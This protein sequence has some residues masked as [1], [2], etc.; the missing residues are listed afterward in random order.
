[1]PDSIIPGPTLFEISWEV[2]HR[3]GGIHTVVSTKARTLAARYQGEHRDDYVV[4][5]PWL[6]EQHDPDAVLDPEPA[7]A[8]FEESCRK[9]GLPVRVG[10]WRVPGRPLTILVEFSSLYD[11]KDEILADLWTEHQVDSLFGGWSYVEP[12]L[13]GHAAGMVIEH[14]WREVVN[15]RRR[16][17]VVQAHEWMTG[18]ALMYLSRRVP[19]IGTVFTTHATVIGRAA[20]ERGLLGEN[21]LGGKTPAEAAADLGVRARH[22]IEAASARLADVFTTVSRIAA[23]EA[24]VFHERIPDPVLPNGLDPDVLAARIEGA[25]QETAAGRLRDVASRFLGED[26]SD[27]AV[28]CMSGRYEFRNKGID[29]TLEAAAALNREPGRTIVLFLLVPAGNSGLRRRVSERLAAAEPEGGGPIGISLHHLHDSDGDPI[30]GRCTEL[31]LDNAPGSRVRIVFWSDYLQPGDGILGLRYEAVLQGADATCFPS[32]YEAWGYTPQESLALG[33]PTI[34]TDLAGFGRWAQEEGLAGGDCTVVLARRD[35][36]DADVALE[37]AATLERLTDAG[38]DR[39]TLNDC[40]R[41]VTAATNWSKLISAYDDAHARAAAAAQ[42]RARSLPG[43][44]PSHRVPV[45]SAGQ[46]GRPH[47]FALDVETRIPPAIAGLEE[48]ASNWWWTSDAAATALFEEVCPATWERVRRAPIR[49]LRETQPARLEELASDTEFVARVDETVSRL[50]AY[51]S[52][53]LDERNVSAHRPVAYVCAEFGL[54]ESFPIYS[55]G[56][57]V[58]AGDHLRA[59]SDLGVPLVA[60]GLLYRAG[61]MRQRLRGGI[62]QETE[63]ERVDPADLPLTAAVD[64]D[65]RP[66][67]VT[68]QLPGSEVVLRAW[69]TDVGRVPLYLLDADVPSNRQDDRTLTRSLY[70]GDQ[71]MRI[72]QEIVLGLGS[73]RL[74]RALGIEPSVYHVNEGHGAFTALERVHWLL[75]NTGL[76]FETAHETVRA[77]TVFTTHTPVPAG[78]DEFPEDLVRRYFGHADRW[79]GVP[80]ERFMALGEAVDKPGQFNMTGLAVRFAARVNGVSERHAEVSRPLLQRFAPQL[81]ASEVPVHS[82]TNGVHLGLWTRPA[83][84]DALGASRF[85]TLADAFRGATDSSDAALWQMRETLRSDLRTHLIAHLHKSFAEQGDSPALLGRIEEQLKPDALYIGFARRFATYKRAGLVFSEPDRLLDLLDDPDRPVRLVIAGKAHPRDT[86]AQELLARIGTLARDPRFVGRVIV[87]ENYDMGVAR[88]LVAGVDL[89][90]NTPRRPLEA[91]G[92]S[93]MKAAA[94]GVLNLSVGDG[95]WLEGADGANGWTI[96]GDHGRDATPANDALHDA[97]DATS[98]LGLLR[99]EVIPAFFERDQHGRPP[100]WL[101]LVRRCLV[102]LPPAFDAAR[103]VAEYR[104]WAYEP[105]ASAHADLARDRYN[106]ARD[107]FHDLERVRRTLPAAR[108]TS[109][110]I[111][112]A[113]SVTVGD[114]LEVEVEIELGEL[115]DGDVVVEALVG[116]RA[117]DGGLAEVEAVR[118]TPDGVSA[119]GHARY[120]GAL[121]PREAGAL[122][123]AVRIRPDRAGGPAFDDPVVWA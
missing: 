27:A 82:V 44:P 106:G 49:L 63:P 107:A 40:C 76:S 48:I 120:V 13:F 70:D 57:G 20:A 85:D 87:L 74:L 66:V 22:S 45:R 59:A 41:T 2:A 28:V 94:N 31:G 55:G 93:G 34:T 18:A 102:S 90:L 6:L 122:G 36:D 68:L 109:A 37:L 123:Y 50:R 33:V 104:E 58:L 72:R 60:V 52:Q 19:E 25:S 56:L 92:T 51:R 115:T 35:R 21:A 4:I 81:M 103:M 24:A 29:V 114:R 110:S 3:V 78:H 15:G 8:D 99:H 116:R 32:Y 84:R 38:V 71:S 113:H 105:L 86:E 61:Y 112:D 62:Q 98:L 117:D 119:A 95:W 65:G 67:E 64:A 80:W 23:A 75:R 88:W 17:A 101:A 121:T 79:S 54:H 83:T 12:V 16:I 43:P 26:M 9:L 96:G 5:G 73:V 108:I 10:R 97:H 118:L 47:V 53:A 111:G 89:W 11:R 100:A 39:K 69:R 42:A 7:Y 30:L 77:T 14:W 91:S 1:M 46:N